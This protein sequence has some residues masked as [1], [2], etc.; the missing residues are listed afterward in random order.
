MKKNLIAILFAILVVVG[1]AHCGGPETKTVPDVTGQPVA[2]AIETLNNAGYYNQ[3]LQYPNG[4]PAYSGIVDRQTPKAGAEKPTD[5]KITL[6]MKDTRMKLQDHAAKAEQEKKE[7]EQKVKEKLDQVAGE[8]KGKNAMEAMSR[9]EKEHMTGRITTGSGIKEDELK[10][11]IKEYADMGI[12]WVVTEATPR[13]DGDNGVIDINVDTKA[14]A[15]AATK[16]QEQA[17]SLEGKL[18]ESAA[19]VACEEY[20]ERQFPAGFKAHMFSKTATP[21]DNDTWFVR[22]TVDVTNAYGAKMKDRTCDCKVTGTTENPQV[23]EF[24]VY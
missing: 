20:G 23:V 11:T 6:T 5:T 3:T 13:M 8:I 19:I 17:D 16:R 2:Q 12:E 24:T 15:D 22:M 1:L 10:Q 9:L 7:K 21:A 18:N 14:R 4:D